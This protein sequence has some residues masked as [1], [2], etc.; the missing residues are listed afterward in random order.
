MGSAFAGT[1][2]HAATIQPSKGSKTLILLGVETFILFSSF[3]VTAW[4]KRIVF[5][6]PDRAS[7]LLNAVVRLRDVTTEGVE[8]LWCGATQ[9]PFTVAMLSPF[10]IPVK[11]K[12]W[13]RIQLRASS[14]R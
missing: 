10:R 8:I 11:H 3:R 4:P 2:L 12:P 5:Q 7:M 9:A 13:R 6:T 1:A 14:V